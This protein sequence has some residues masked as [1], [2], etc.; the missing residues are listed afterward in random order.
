[1]TVK[2]SLPANFWKRYK[3][4]LRLFATLQIGSR[5]KLKEWPRERE[6]PLRRAQLNT[7]AQICRKVPAQPAETFSEALQSVWFIQLVLQIESN[8][9][10]VSL[11]RFDQ[12]LYPYYK[13]DKNAGAP[14]RCAGARINRTLLGQTQY[15]KQDSPMERYTISDRIPNVSKM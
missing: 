5:K 8:G 13:A 7:I 3:L 14:R 9:H 1:M 15:D 11:G 10:S 2:E 12:Y 6:E 4:S